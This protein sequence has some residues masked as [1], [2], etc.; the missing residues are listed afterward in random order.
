MKFA[1]ISLQQ[2]GQA[3]CLL[4]I[5]NRTCFIGVIVC[6][7]SDNKSLDMFIL[8]SHT[9]LLML[10]LY[11]PFHQCSKNLRNVCYVWSVQWF[12]NLINSVRV[13][14]W[15]HFSIKTLDLHQLISVFG[16]WELW[17]R[18]PQLLSF[19]VK[20]WRAFVEQ[21]KTLNSSLKTKVVFHWDHVD[22]II[23]RQNNYVGFCLLCSNIYFL[24]FIF[25]LLLLLPLHLT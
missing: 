11:E 19:G 25:V 2:R 5:S 14:S 9:H 8:T 21:I 1:N 12:E 22:F 3:C 15:T 4:C 17:S 16:N 24:Y 10:I 13:K 23:V 6:S 18:F 7:S 20:R